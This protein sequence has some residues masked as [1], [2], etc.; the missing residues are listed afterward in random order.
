M[1]IPAV[2][3]YC[4][5]FLCRL[6]INHIMECKDEHRTRTPVINLFICWSRIFTKIEVPRI[7]LKIKIRLFWPS[8][9]PSKKVCF[10]YFLSFTYF[11]RALTLLLVNIILNFKNCKKALS[12]L[13]LNP[14]QTFSFNEVFMPKTLC[15]CEYRTWF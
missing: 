12:K 5:V 6:K 2:I 7:C 8:Y 4:L 13:F 3:S 14:W 15:E 11:E 10:S 1:N 9:D